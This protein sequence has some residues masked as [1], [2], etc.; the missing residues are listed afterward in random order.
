MYCPNCGQSQISEE[1][2]YCSRCGISLWELARWLTEGANAPWNQVQPVTEP[3]PRKKGIRRGLKL[4]FLSGVLVL[5]VLGLGAVEE[6]LLA[7]LVFPL[8]VFLAGLFWA[9]YCRLFAD[10]RPKVAA[11]MPAQLY[12]QNEY[13]P[14][15]QVNPAPALRAREPNTSEIV[16]PPSVTEY[17]TNL[18]RNRK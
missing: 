1:I 4:M 13:L 15:A 6:E 11:K 16:Q 14:P 2:R 3:S 5:P 18:L 8:T 10:D 17:T 7:L 9:L 12:R